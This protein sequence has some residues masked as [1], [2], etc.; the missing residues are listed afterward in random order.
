MNAVTTNVKLYHYLSPGVIDYMTQAR[1]PGV[2]THLPPTMVRGRRN[3][4][5]FGQI[6]GVRCHRFLDVNQL[7]RGADVPERVF[8][9]GHIDSFPGAS[10]HPDSSP[11]LVP[12]EP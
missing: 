5:K 1:T 4:C 10:C 11:T 2:A 3:T 6:E 9:F 7:R 12:D 8:R